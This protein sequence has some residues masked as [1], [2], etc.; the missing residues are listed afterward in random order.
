MFVLPEQCSPLFSM[1]TFYTK[2]YR[3]IQTSHPE[4]S[5]NVSITAHFQGKFLLVSSTSGDSG[6]NSLVVK[7]IS[8]FLHRQ[9]NWWP[10]M[11]VS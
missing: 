5:E 3:P 11:V 2:K 10:T 6:I 4:I 8:I 7:Q 9:K 1:Q